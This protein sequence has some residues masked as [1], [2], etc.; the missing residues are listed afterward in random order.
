LLHAAFFRAAIINSHPI[1]DVKEALALIE[2]HFK[3]G[4]ATSTKI[5]RA[6]FNVKGAVRRGARD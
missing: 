5:M 6:P 2:R 1:E 4:R 3:V